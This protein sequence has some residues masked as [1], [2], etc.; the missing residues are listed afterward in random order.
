MRSLSRLTSGLSIAAA[1]FAAAALFVTLSGEPGQAQSDQSLLARLLSR[2]LS[3]DEASVRI[4]AIDGA[5]SSNAV[6]RDLQVSDRNGVWLQMDQARLVWNRTALLRGRVEVNTLEIGRIDV[7][8]TPAPSSAPPPPSTGQEAL[9][10]EAPVKI[11]VSKFSLADL[12]LGAPVLG[13]AARLSAQ[14]SAS[15]GDPAEGLQLDLRATR[16]DA[17]GQFAILLN[18]LP[19]TQRLRLDINH[20]EP[21][22]GLVAR[23]L[24]LPG[25][26]PVELRLAGDDTLANFTARLNFAAGPTIGAQ[27]EARVVRQDNFYR[28]T[29]GLE[30]R[31]AG[32]APP[33]L[34]PILEGATRLDGELARFDDGRITLDKLRIASAA[35]ELDVAGSIS[36]NQSL[37]VRV[38]GRAI[39]RE[40]TLKETRARVGGA[41]IGAFDL[42]L[43]AKGKLSAPQMSGAVNAREVK[44]SDWSLARLDLQLGADPLPNTTDRFSFSA[45]GAAEGLRLA[46]PARNR[47]IGGRITIDMRGVTDT[48]GLTKVDVA[49]IE[50]PTASLVF[51]GSI[52][53][54]ELAGRVVA[55][56]PALAPFSGVAGAPLRGSA[57]IAANLSGDPAARV[58]ARLDGQLEEVVTGQRAID[59]AFGRMV[60][61]SGLIARSPE[62]L[63]LDG[64]RID[65]ANIDLTAS[66][67]SDDAGLAFDVKA[68]VANLERLH[69]GIKAGRAQ[70]TARVEG[71]AAAPRV[72][73]SAT[74][75]DASAMDRAI[76]QLE[77]GFDATL[78]EAIRAALTLSGDVGGKPAMGKVEVAQIGGGWSFA[79]DKFTIGSASIDGRVQLDSKNLASGNLAVAATDLDDLTPLLLSRL[80]GRLDARIALAV[81]DGKQNVDI[82]AKGARLRFEDMR[83][84]R[85]L[86]DARVRDAL[87]APSIDGK[88][89]AANLRA[90]SQTFRLIELVARD[91]GKGS[92]IDIKAD[93]QGFALA[94]AGR[95]PA[96]QRRLDLARFEARRSGASVRLDAPTTLSWSDDGLTIN[97]AA[98]RIGTGVATINGRVGDTV[99]LDAVLRAVPLSAAQIVYP[100]LGL[101]GVVNGRATA[102]G[103]AS[104]LNGDFDLAVTG[105]SNAG[106]R[107]AG[108]QPLAA[109]AK[110]RFENGRV[111]LDGT[112]NA[113]RV[114]QIKFGG[115]APMAAAGALDLAV[116][117]RLDL[118][119]ANA[120]L[121]TSGVR[122]TGRADV[123]VRIGGDVSNPRPQGG[124]IIA[125]GGIEDPTRGVR[126]TDLAARLA[127][128]GETIV[129]ESASARTP[130]GGT[131]SVAGRIDVNPAAGF[132]A[133]LRVTGRRAQL[134]SNTTTTA[135]A[136]LDLTL[137][138]PLTQAPQIGGRVNLVTLDVTLPDQLPTV[139]QPL[140]NARHLAPPPQSQA[141]LAERRKAERVRA[142]GTPFNAKLDLS[143]IAA[144]RLFVRGRGVEAELGGELRL[145]GTSQD[146]QAVGAFDLRRGRFDLLGQRINLTRGRLDF[147]GEL[148]PN[149]D[150][151]AETRAG[152]VTARI[153][154][155][156][157]AAS[158]TFAISSSPEL[159][160]DEVISR[161]L[162][163]RAAGGLSS[164][165]ALQ[166]AQAIAVLSGGS[167]GAFE[168]VRRSL[169][170]DSLDVT[171]GA[172]GG[173]AVGASRYISDRVRLGVRAGASPEETGVSVDVDITR[174]FKAKTEVGAD[175]STS[176]GA[177]YEWEW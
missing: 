104:A 130:N 164:G 59:G 39:P 129:V 87:G 86:A 154:V 61:I 106:V 76:R 151:V 102:R 100:G 171:T 28:I 125:G 109:N 30:A 27:G 117:G 5:L 10:P 168:S 96:G 111:R 8:R 108:L 150:L 141:R 77:V 70:A 62:R 32:I 34:A 40:A 78:G 89:E 132:P 107:Q 67:K 84:E 93:A 169:G 25:L 56:L 38:K 101:A 146:P 119:G 121:S 69:P 114:G 36:A 118:A 113:P 162:F 48:D 152:D 142:A 159:P 173:P 75:R 73:G 18:Y 138:G 1:G 128:R 160:Q 174:R 58:E 65:G 123:N 79:A 177:G 47:A 136:D 72:K 90:S 105:F 133:D 42:D 13:T 54:R 2:A 95:I 50:T 127:A 124:V 165:Q 80:E 74:V 166:L 52:G 24:D 153:A 19:Q 14:G 71:P 55:R 172:G 112:V 82:D 163:Q 92:A 170:V 11:V 44:T 35:A 29:T 17:I 137:R 116:T 149:I 94:G 23:M 6:I 135:I 156:G 131:I 68:A 12:A 31:V 4:G 91:D 139:Q 140:P 21:E 57:Q 43:T 161:V 85:L 97:K 145:T 64:V 147:A 51:T 103:P 167:S 99:D 120:V 53:P 46:D 49:R 158:P 110:G 175:G 115:T 98:V 66:G 143:I 122:L 15:L 81:V 83:L 126:I 20:Q 26:P 134:A 63:T 7:L 33:L 45:K 37:D 148:T 60:R 9:L 155:E 41:E 3:T 22:G 144:N 176:V 88:I 157:P 16:T